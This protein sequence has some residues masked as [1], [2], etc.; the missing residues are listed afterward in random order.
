[1]RAVQGFAPVFEAVFGKSTPTSYLEVNSDN[2]QELPPS[3]NIR[4][5]PT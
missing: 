4:S 1:V 5:I 2:E 3:F